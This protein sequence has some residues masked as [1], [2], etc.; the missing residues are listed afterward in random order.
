MKKMLPLTIV[1]GCIAVLLTSCF[2]R[3]ANAQETKTAYPNM[4]P[5]EQYLIADRSEEIAFARSAAPESISRDAEIMVLGKHGYETA[6]KG[7]NGFVCFVWRSWAAGADDPE[8]W[9]PKLRAP[10]C[11]NQPAVRSYLPNTIK[12]TDLVLAGSPKEKIFT[13]L[14]AAFD[15]KELPPPEPNAM[16]YMMSKQGY[17]SD[18]GGHWHPHLM[19]FTPLTEPATWG[20]FLPGSPVIAFTEKE[21]HVSVFLIPVGHWSDGTEAPA[22]KH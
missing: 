15:K 3:R 7:N 16:C 18:R 19:I 2:T 20:A 6:V 22:Y 14:A 12:R 17:L 4:A 10:A 8:F 13:A 5:L 1:A 21:A 9:N 11:L